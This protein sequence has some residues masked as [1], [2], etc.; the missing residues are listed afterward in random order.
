MSKA[1]EV[2]PKKK[3]PNDNASKSDLQEAIKNTIG[4]KATQEHKFHPER[5]WSFDVAILSEKIAIEIEGGSYTGGRHTRLKG[6]QS[7]ME[8]YNEAVR[9]GWKVIRITP[10]QVNSSYIIDLI[11]DLIWKDTIEHISQTS[12]TGSASSKKK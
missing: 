9:L 5:K 4:A 3:R 6:F 1:T 12:A 7:D 2:K 8:K 11:S 10:Q